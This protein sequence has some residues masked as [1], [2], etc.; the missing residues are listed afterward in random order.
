MNASLKL[1]HFLQIIFIYAKVRWVKID[2]PADVTV[3]TY[4][5]HLLFTLKSDWTVADKTYSAGALITIECEKYLRGNRSFHV[6]FEP[7]DRDLVGRNESTKNYLILNVLENIRNKVL[8]FQWRNGNWTQ[9]DFAI[10][11]FGLPA[12]GELILMNQMP[13]SCNIPT[14]SLRQV[15]GW[16]I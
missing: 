14:P 9:K 13:I 12:F 2:K 8:L 16:E 4:G 10:P 6:L 3:E 7:T 5:E 11:S 1:P 15:S